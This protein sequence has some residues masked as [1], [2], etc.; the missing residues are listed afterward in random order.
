MAS[1]SSVATDNYSWGGVASLSE[2]SKDGVVS[3]Q[4]LGTNVGDQVKLTLQQ[5][6]GGSFIDVTN[7]NNESVVY[8]GAVDANGDEHGETRTLEERLPELRRLNRG[9]SRK[10]NKQ[11][12]RRRKHKERINR[13]HQKIK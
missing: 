12:N 6:D 7:G 9:L 1:I 4:T 10:T 11:S 8:L 3:I 2:I 13:F 5:N